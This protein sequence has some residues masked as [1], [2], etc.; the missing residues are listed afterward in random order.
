M[1]LDLTQPTGEDRCNGGLPEQRTRFEAVKV[2]SSGKLEQGQEEGGAQHW[3]G[4]PKTPEKDRNSSR[5]GC[6]EIS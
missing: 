2:S 6:L 4:N 5:E 1:P 3:D